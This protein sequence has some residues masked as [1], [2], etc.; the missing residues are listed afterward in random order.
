MLPIG[1]YQFNMMDEMEQ[2]EIIWDSQFIG[3]RTD[4]TFVYKCY[5]YN[6]FYI[7]TKRHIENDVLVGLRSFRNPDLLQ[8]YFDNMGDLNLP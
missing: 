3:E 5:Q 4:E 7:E 1:I 8:P 6:D 2:Q